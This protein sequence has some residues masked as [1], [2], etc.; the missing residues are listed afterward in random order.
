MTRCLNPLM[1]PR[2]KALDIAVSEGIAARSKTA[3]QITRLK[4]LDIAV[5]EGTEA[6]S[7]GTTFVR[8]KALDIAV[9]EGD[10]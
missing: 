10:P 2:L 7:V 4:A 1:S 8:L 6:P 3:N 5:S 9:S